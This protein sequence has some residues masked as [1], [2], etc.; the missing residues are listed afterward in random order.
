[1]GNNS[2]SETKTKEFISENLNLLTKT[3]QTCQT[4]DEATIDT[5]VRGS[6][7]VRRIG[8]VN[9]LTIKLDSACAQKAL[10]NNKSRQ[11]LDNAV[12][13]MSKE[14]SQSVSAKA[15]DSDSSK[16]I[17]DLTTKLSTDIRNVYKSKCIHDFSQHITDVIS[18]SENVDVEQNKN[19]LSFQATSNCVSSSKVVNDTAQ[20]LK[21]ALDASA[22]TTE[23]NTVAGI[24]GS[25]LSG[26][27]LLLIAVVVVAIVLG[28]KLMG[29]GEDMADS[30][31]GGVVGNDPADEMKKKLLMAAIVVLIIALI[32]YYYKKKHSKK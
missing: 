28:P 5:S 7:G 29:A 20:K 10:N 25:L 26:P 17:T 12:K 3:T 11:A 16:T 30:A 21:Q 23:E 4:V 15:G 2:S 8:N 14:L 13:A 22:S 18:G 1:M 32:Y 27:M 6:K 24:L 9:R 19:E 31:A